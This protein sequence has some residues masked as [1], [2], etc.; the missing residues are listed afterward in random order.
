MVEPGVEALKR[1]RLSH[2]DQAYMNAEAYSAANAPLIEAQAEA[3]LAQA[4]G[5]GLVA[6]IDGMRFVVPVPSMY[7]R[8]NRKYFGPKRG[9]TWLNMVNDQAAGLGAKVVSGTAR[10][11]CT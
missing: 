8:P 7:A 10:D 11:S 2:V 4:W 1:D 9:V 6:A 3:S 5:G